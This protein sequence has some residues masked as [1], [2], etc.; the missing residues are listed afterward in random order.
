MS[1]HGYGGT[2][3]GYDEW[4][5]A[6]PDDE[7]DGER[8][9]REEKEKEKEEEEEEEEERAEEQSTPKSW[10]AEVIADSSGVW[11]GNALRFATEAEALEYASALASRW[12]L[13]SGWRAVPCDDEVE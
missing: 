1:D 6:T 11:C 13:V 7:S 12:T 10:K 8:G 9:E 2:I 4:K 5:L 3:R